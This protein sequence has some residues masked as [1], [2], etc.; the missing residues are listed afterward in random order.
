V[1]LSPPNFSMVASARMSAVIASATTP[2]AGTA[3]TSLR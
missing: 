3:V 1:T 2:A